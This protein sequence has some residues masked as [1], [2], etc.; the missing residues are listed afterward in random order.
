VRRTLA[1]SVSLLAVAVTAPGGEAVASQ[2][3]TA[4]PNPVDFGETLVIRGKGWPVIEFCSRTVRLSLRSAQNAFRIGRTRT[5]PSGRFR[6]DWI[7]R[8]SEVGAGRWRLV[9]RVRCESGRDGSP[10]IVRASTPL[11]IR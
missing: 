8:R 1:V 2:R 9:A 5:R 10:V 6:F 7:P 3:V 4:R 11:R